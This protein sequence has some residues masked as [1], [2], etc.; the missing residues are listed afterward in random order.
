MAYSGYLIKLGGSSGT[1]LPAKFIQ[2][3][4]YD[5]STSRAEAQSSTSV[6]GLL[7]RTVVEHT[8]SKITFSTPKLTNADVAELTAILSA[9]WT[10]AQ[11]R[12]ISVYYYDPETDSYK[13]GTFYM[14]DIKYQI[15]RLDNAQNIVYYHPAAIELNEY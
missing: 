9:T 5:V 13:T 15:I 8:R 3:D 6:T 12:K 7:H 1:T 14:Q 2:Y 4:S 10:D 11:N